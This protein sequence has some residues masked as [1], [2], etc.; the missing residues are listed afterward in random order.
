MLP[1]RS[2]L[3]VC[4]LLDLLRAFLAP[5][6]ATQIATAL[7]A[8]ARVLFPLL[9][10]QVQHL[11][12][13]ASLP[14]LSPLEPEQDKRRLFA[15]LAEVFTKQ[16]TSRPVLLVIED[17]HWSDESTL[18]FLLFF[19]RK[20][21]A[22]RLLVV[23]TYRSDELSQPLRSLLAQLDRER[24]RQE[25]ALVR[26]TRTNTETMLSAILQGI[27]LL[28]ESIDDPALREH[29]ELTAFATLPKEKPV[30][31]RRATASQYDGLTEREREVAALIGQG[32]SNAEIAEQLVVSKRT[33]ETYV[34]NMLSKLGVPSRYQITLWARDKGLVPPKQ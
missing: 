34:S 13:V 7:G 19:V 5:L 8:S 1:Y 24:L 29:F 3:P 14:P 17:I 11:P 32:Q 30:S 25:I 2:L 12:E 16:A 21:A 4:P 26:L 22:H 23:L 27:A 10:E 20:T 15:A 31:P 33:V 18:E 6:S 9:P 28:S